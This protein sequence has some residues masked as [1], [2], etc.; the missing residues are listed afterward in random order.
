MVKKDSTEWINTKVELKNVLIGLLVLLIIILPT[1]KVSYETYTPYE[2]E[3]TYIEEVIKYETE[4]R[5]IEKK[6]NL[7][8]D[9]YNFKSENM[10]EATTFYS[11]TGI[12]EVSIISSSGDKFYYAITNFDDCSSGNTGFFETRAF[13]KVS[14]EL[15]FGY[16]SGNPVVFSYYVNGNQNIKHPNCIII[17]NEENRGNEIT[18]DINKVT[19]VQETVE[20]PYLE[21]TEK[22]RTVTKYK[23]ETLYTKVNWLFG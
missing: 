11:T 1:K 4:E 23:K 10:F 15:T 18:I 7:I 12:N 17:R 2:I 9:T 19:T 13:K 16:V 3:E 22:T 14:G 6:E 20:T 8:F 5:E 21:T